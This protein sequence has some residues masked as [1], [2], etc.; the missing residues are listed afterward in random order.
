MTKE[1]IQYMKS[2]IISLFNQR[3]FKSGMY[4]FFIIYKDDVIRFIVDF[5]KND[6]NIIVETVLYHCFTMALKNNCKLQDLIL[7]DKGEFIVIWIQTNY[8][9]Q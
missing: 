7:T 9:M 1:E 5:E 4:S 2:D 8:T 6:F 3:V